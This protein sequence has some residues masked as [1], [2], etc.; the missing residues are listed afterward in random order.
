MCNELSIFEKFIRLIYV[1]IS[2]CNTAI[3]LNKMSI[4]FEYIYYLELIMANLYSCLEK[5]YVALNA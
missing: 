2:K 4:L 5:I 1:F 3:S